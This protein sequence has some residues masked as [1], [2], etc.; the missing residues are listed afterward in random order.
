MKLALF[1]EYVPAVVNGDRIVDVSGTVG[2]SVMNLMPGD[3]MIEIITRFDEFRPKLEQATKATGKPISE[4]KLRSPMPQPSKMI[5]GLGNYKENIESPQ[6]PLDVFLKS[7]SSILDPG[8]TV[9]FPPHDAMIFHHEAELGVVIGRRGK[10]ITENH[11]MDHVFGY[12]CVIDVSARGIGRSGVGFLQKSPETFGPLGPWIVTK[13][14]VPD[15]QKLSVKLWVDGQLRQDYNTDD[16]EHPIIKLISWS[17]SVATLEVGDVFGCGTNHQGLGPLQ[18]G[19]TAT[20]EVERVGKMSVKISDPLKRKWPVGI[21]R[22]M[23]QAVRN[24]RLTGQRPSF[25]EMFK[26]RRIG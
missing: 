12:L 17:S 20:I 25:E 9:V 19:E 4:V 8:G 23:G 6:R 14:E 10:N 21:D 26:T 15:P 2:A 7:P 22:S 5:Y 1:N 24:M 16:M 13:D 11:A 3:R 18:D